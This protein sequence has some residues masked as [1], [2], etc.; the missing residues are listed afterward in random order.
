MLDFNYAPSTGLPYIALV[1][2]ALRWIA[3]PIAIVVIAATFREPIGRL[4]KNIKN[5][6]VAGSRVE[7]I[8][9]QLGSSDTLGEVLP[10]DQST[11]EGL[12]ILEQSL[13]P[14]QRAIR[15]TVKKELEDYPEKDRSEILVAAVA[16]ERLLRHFTAA[17]SNMFGSQIRSLEILNQRNGRIT[18]DEASKEYSELQKEIPEL[19]SWT[20]ERY[21]S[22]LR[23]FQLIDLDSENIFLTDIGRDFIIWLNAVGADKNKPL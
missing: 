23:R 10:S 17:Y 1:V 8:P 3:W 13:T 12:P 7:F 4:I 20:L 14:A 6:T 5:F 22:Y 9:Q 15:D 16:K 18:L 11:K 19:S 2:E 21:I